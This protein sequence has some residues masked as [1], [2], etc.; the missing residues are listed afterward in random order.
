M[1]A[2]EEVD[3]LVPRIYGPLDLV[4]FR[5]HN[6]SGYP[7]EVLKH[8]FYQLLN[9]AGREASIPA[10][11]RIGIEWHPL[12]DTPEGREELREKSINDII[13]LSVGMHDTRAQLYWLVDGIPRP[14]WDKYPQSIPSAFSRVIE[15]RKGHLLEHWNTDQARKDQILKYHDL[16]QEF[17]AV[18]RR[19][20]IVFVVAQ[21]KHELHLEE[22]YLDPEVSW[23]GPFP[24]GEDLWPEGIRGPVRAS[25]DGYWMWS[26][27]YYCSYVLSW[28]PI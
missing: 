14:Q 1:P 5:L 15:K 21:W 13:S 27:D 24:G 22:S 12:W 16:Y 17:E 2:P 6:A 11:R 23:T 26:A 9:S 28:E 8:V 25:F 19:Y 7:K 10:F 3:K 20:Y 4:V 18:G